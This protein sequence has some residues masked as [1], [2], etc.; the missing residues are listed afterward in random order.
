MYIIYIDDSW[1]K[2]TYCFSAIAIREDHWKHVFRNLRTWRKTINR[3]DGVHLHKELHATDFV[4]GRGRISSRTITKWRRCQ[5][6]REGLKLLDEQKGLRIFNVCSTQ[7]LEQAFERL[8]NRINRAME[9]A[10]SRAILICDEGSER[11]YTRLARKMAVH[12]FIASRY[13]RWPDGTHARNVPTNHIVEDPVFKNSAHSYLVQCAD[14][15]VYALLQKERPHPAR[16][17][18][19]LDQAYRLIRR[20]FVLK[21]HRPDPDGIIR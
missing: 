11:V 21:A 17:K 9:I 12:N 2:G 15:C 13:G 5:L 3:T 19:G 4:A 14:F 7:S 8:L 16:M 20:R 6:F 10:Q 18:Y 1:S